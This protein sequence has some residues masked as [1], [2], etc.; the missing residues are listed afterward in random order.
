[1]KCQ[2]VL[3]ID[4]IISSRLY[5]FF[6]LNQIFYHRDS[7][8]VFNWILFI[9]CIV[10]R[11]F[12]LFKLH[13]GLGKTR[14]FKPSLSLLRQGL[15]KSPNGKNWILPIIPV[16]AKVSIKLCLTI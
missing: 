6:L 14:F 12:G 8:L 13:H 5:N 16:Y 4:F 2:V 10:E 3:S 1:M 9:C 15:K 7:I 11:T